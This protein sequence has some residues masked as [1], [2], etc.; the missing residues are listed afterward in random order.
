MEALSQEKIKDQAAMCSC[1][2]ILHWCPKMHPHSV[3]F[4]CPCREHAYLQFLFRDDLNRLQPRYVYLTASSPVSWRFNEL[5]DFDFC[6][7]SS[8]CAIAN[9]GLDVSDELL[10]ESY[11]IERWQKLGRLEMRSAVSHHTRKKYECLKTRFA[12]LPF[13]W[14]VLSIDIG[15]ERSLA[16]VVMM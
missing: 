6:L 2:I 10:C 12:A 8:I 14:N 15:A 16:A 13:V 9:V 5:S 4:P 3:M 7:F 1:V 11:R